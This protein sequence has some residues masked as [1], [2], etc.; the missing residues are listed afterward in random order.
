MNAQ[1]ATKVISEYM[2]VSKPYAESLDALV[3]VW[4]KLKD[5]DVWIDKLESRH[6]NHLSFYSYEQQEKYSPFDLFNYVEEIGCNI[7]EVCCIT[8]AKAIKELLA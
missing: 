5:D 7:Y 6:G 2:G 4:D 1:E 3:P 8:T